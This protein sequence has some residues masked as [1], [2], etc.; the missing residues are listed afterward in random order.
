[1]IMSLYFYI[2][3]SKTCSW[4]CIFFM[5]VCVSVCVDSVLV[6]IEVGLKA[7]YDQG[8]VFFISIEDFTYFYVVCYL[9]FVLLGKCRARIRR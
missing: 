8:V 1:M 4:G 6:M 7:L 9:C 2:Y 5:F 3:I